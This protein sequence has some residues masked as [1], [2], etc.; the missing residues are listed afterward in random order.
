MCHPQGGTEGADKVR[1]A[2]KAPTKDLPTTR[3]TYRGRCLLLL[4]RPAWLPSVKW[5]ISE[6]VRPPFGLGL[7][8][9]QKL[10]ILLKGARPG[11]RAEASS[12]HGMLP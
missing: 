7:T 12:A 11:E 5:S 8:L 4:S 9:P 6:A 1:E 10:S 2:P 3:V